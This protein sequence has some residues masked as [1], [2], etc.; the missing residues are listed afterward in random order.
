VW[1]PVE[2]SNGRLTPFFKFEARQTAII[3]CSWLLHL[4]QQVQIL[5]KGS[6]WPLLYVA[7]WAAQPSEDKMRHLFL[8]NMKG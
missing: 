6:K 3:V 8:M 5:K 4:T 2:E 1:Q 7:G